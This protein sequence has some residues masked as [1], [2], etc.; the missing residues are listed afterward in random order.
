MKT[1]IS[2][3]LLVAMF[4]ASC[5]SSHI[6]YDVGLSKV[7][8]PSEDASKQYYDSTKIVKTEKRGKAKYKFEDNN[9]AVSWVVGIKTFTFELKNKTDSY[10]KIPWFDAAYINT[11]GETQEVTH[12]G[13]EKY[14]DHGS[15][16]SVIVISKDEV[17]NDVII[18][19]ANISYDASA[20]FDHDWRITPIFGFPIDRKHI[21]EQKGAYIDRTVKIVLPIII[22]GIKNE[23]VFEFRINDVTVKWQPFFMRL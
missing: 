4:F 21:K 1:N 10:I 3:C 12:C 17:L 8:A 14:L 2:I 9:I 5:S 19:T 20:P 23:Y 7:E 16:Q 15:S 13:D 11:A 18:P 22:E 6:I